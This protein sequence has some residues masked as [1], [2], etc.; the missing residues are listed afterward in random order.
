M[1]PLQNLDSLYYEQNYTA[2]HST[3]QLWMGLKLGA[4]ICVI[5]RVS[6]SS[7]RD[8]QSAD[9]SEALLSVSPLAVSRETPERGDVRA[10]KVN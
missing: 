6:W 3:L 4:W 8:L 9:Q 7:G 2:K 5:R 1:K 10:H